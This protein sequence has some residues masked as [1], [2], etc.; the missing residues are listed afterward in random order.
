MSKLIVLAV[1]VTTAC[2]AA[3]P[4]PANPV[5]PEPAPVARKVHPMVGDWVGTITLAY[6][7]AGQ[8]T[9]YGEKPFS[10]ELNAAPTSL[11]GVGGPCD[12][13][14]MPDGDDVMFPAGQLCSGIKNGSELVTRLREG[15]MQ[16]V[17]GKL[18]LSLVF[19]GDAGDELVV[20]AALARRGPRSI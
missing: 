3:V 4:P 11:G 20:R 5:V 2:G 9:H 17:D 14:A 18:Q 6:T 16:I 13:R 12:L 10:L 8:P 15:R 19:D 7:P 1:L